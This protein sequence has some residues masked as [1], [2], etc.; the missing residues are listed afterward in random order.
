[1]APRREILDSDDEDGDF[2]PK[3]DMKEVVDLTQVTT[4]GRPTPAVPADIWDFPASPE[5]AT[6]AGSSGVAQTASIKKKV[7]IKL[8]KAEKRKSTLSSSIHGPEAELSPG[9]S[10]A[11]SVTH[12]DV[13]SPPEPRQK[14]RRVSS[15][16]QA[17]PNSQ[18]VDLLVIPR[19]EDK[20]V[21]SDSTFVTPVDNS[22]SIVEDS[23][24][25]RTTTSLLVVPSTTMT[26]SQKEEYKFV[27]LSSSETDRSREQPGLPQIGQAEYLHKSSGS[28]TIKYPTPIEYASSGR[29]EAHPGEYGTAASNRPRRK[30]NAVHSDPHSSPDI[31]SAPAVI[32]REKHVVS[33][34]NADEEDDS[35]M[36]TASMLPP[37]VRSRG[38]VVSI[39]EE[40]QML[41][42][43]A[44]KAERDPRDRFVEVY[45]L[46]EHPDLEG[47]T[48]HIPKEPGQMK[49]RGTKRKEVSTEAVAEEAL[50]DTAPPRTEEE[51]VRLDEDV[52]ESPVE[53]P[54]KKRR[55]RPRKEPQSQAIVIDD[56]PD[57]FSPDPRETPVPPDGGDETPKPKKKRG[58][59]KKGDAA[60]S[61]EKVAPDESHQDKAVG[62]DITT[63][64][65]GGRTSRMTTSCKDTPGI[66]EQHTGALS[67]R[68]GNSN[69]GAS[70]AK[71]A[72]T[73]MDAIDNAAKE[74][75]VAEAKDKKDAAK[76]RKNGT[77]G[78]SQLS[79]VQ[80]RVGLSRK[81]RIAPLLKSFR[82]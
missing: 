67:E 73:E 65:T 22:S 1:M 72:T 25:A 13:R 61:A 5:D 81:T 52:T 56:D 78:S 62:H 51:R 46:P 41:S 50:P 30:R 24:K 12:S 33:N 28:A 74:N 55:G 32:P 27:S 80:Y 77:P 10:P 49:T 36:A 59:P 63:D 3:S 42:P 66:D 54:P 68:D 82:K 6:K 8:K 23:L 37:K 9:Q 11:L 20:M 21:S 2:S 58:R 79:K 4:P 7:T 39:P 31:I 18:E 43:G 34:W 75:Q 69:L 71:A 57:V 70:P 40:L 60:K 38:K 64:V 17:A 16:R 19:S 45:L 53:P 15:S 35:W 14:R 44:G 26:P 48:T 47:E 76:E 29:R